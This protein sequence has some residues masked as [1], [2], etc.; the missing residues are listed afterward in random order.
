MELMLKW[1]CEMLML[2]LCFSLTAQRKTNERCAE[3]YHFPPGVFGGC[4]WSPFPRRHSPEECFRWHPAAERSPRPSTERT[5]T[6]W[7]FSRGPFIR[8]EIDDK[9]GTIIS[10][11]QRRIPEQ[12]HGDINRQYSEL[13]NSLNNCLGGEGRWLPLPGFIGVSACVWQD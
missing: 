2:P 13:K 1:K 5:Q 6:N 9:L 10:A 8:L 7:V 4:S 3:L 11:S 12:N